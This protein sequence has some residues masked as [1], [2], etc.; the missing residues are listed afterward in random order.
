MF[1]RALTMFRFPTSLDLG[2]LD[3]RLAECALKP[4]GPLEL[5]SR[6]F[7]PPF[8]QA[9]GAMSHRC[10]GALWV[11]LGG[12]D[13][14]LPQSAVNKV[15]QERLDAIKQREGRMPGGRA[16][17]RMLEEVTMSMLPHALVTPLR[18]D[19]LLDTDRGVIAINASGRKAAEGVVAEI[20]RALG[21]FP[22]LP[23]NAEV[24]PRA[25]M[26]GWVAGDP[27]PDGLALGEDCEI[28][29]AADSGGKVRCYRV[30]LGSDE[31]AQ[32][33]EGARQITRLQLV[34]DGAISFDL[35]EQLVVRKF[36]ML[37]GAID[38][39]LDGSDRDDV[40]AELDARFALMAGEFG[41]L[42]DVLEAA[43]KIT[44][45]EP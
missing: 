36:T 16:R 35:D 13:K 31:I 37:D 43:F 10:G 38:K 5:G 44:R 19:A 34:L 12:E 8:G 21:S 3:A 42:F 45:A 25:V 7:V 14:R 1:F 6:G 18:I 27:M 26:T 17:K 29:D 39:L 33:L 41:R 28:R 32:H 9:G 20:R 11:V 23:I 22:A 2:E 24:N 40:A 15:L 30:D 4:V